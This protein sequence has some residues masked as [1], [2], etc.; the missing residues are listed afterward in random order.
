MEP[1]LAHILNRAQA[2]IPEWAR[3]RASPRSPQRSHALS[4]ED[5]RDSWIAPGGRLIIGSDGVPVLFTPS[6]NTTAATTRKAAEPSDTP[7]F[8]SSPNQP[9]ASL[10]KTVALIEA[11]V[12]KRTAQ[13][14]AGAVLPSLLTGGTVRDNETTASSP[15]GGSASDGTIDNKQLVLDES[16]LPLWMFDDASHETVSPEEYLGAAVSS[17]AVFHM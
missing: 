14:L 6:K 2:P 17:A 10:L 1:R 5:S 7:L 8:Q 11:L 3:Q 15:A 12:G 13:Q 16:K 9:S 4:R